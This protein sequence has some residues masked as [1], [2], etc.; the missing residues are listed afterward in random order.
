MLGWELQSQLLAGSSY[1]KVP[2]VCSESD[3]LHEH[4]SDK[5]SA[6][7]IEMCWFFPLETLRS[8]KPRK[9]FLNFHVIGEDKT[10]EERKKW[11]REEDS[12]VRAWGIIFCVLISESPLPLSVD[13]PQGKFTWRVGADKHSI[14]WKSLLLKLLSYCVLIL[15]LRRLMF[16]YPK[17]VTCPNLMLADQW[18]KTNLGC[19]T[20]WTLKNIFQFLKVV[21]VL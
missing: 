1:G 17:K 7:R 11:E 14:L 19:M 9:T 12:D 2:W 6:N 13:H 16:Y 21:S 15:G 10:K 3:C 20:V 8:S 18:P 4:L 5:E